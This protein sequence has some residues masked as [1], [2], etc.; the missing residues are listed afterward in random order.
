MYTA[1]MRYVLKAEYFGEFCRIRDSYGCNS[2]PL[3]PRRSDYFNLT[4]TLAA[5]R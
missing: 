2:S 5:A 4:V 1:T 3:T